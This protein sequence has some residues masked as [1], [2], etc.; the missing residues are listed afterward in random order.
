VSAR[1]LL[2][3]FATDPVARVCSGVNPVLIPADAI[4]TTAN[5]KYLGGGKLVDLPDLDQLINGTAARIDVTVSGVSAAT[6]ALFSGESD[7]LQG[8]TVDVGIAYQDD[9]WQITSVEWVGQL[10]CDT[11]SIQDQAGQSGGRTR[12]I[13]LSLGTDFTDRSRAPSAFFT[14]SDQRRRSPDDQIF[15]HVANYNSGTSRAFGPSDAK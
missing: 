8:C 1:I 10:R 15:D 7:S 3:R 5:A 9:A 2:T 12:S 11:P 4:E 6:L 13:S 14:D